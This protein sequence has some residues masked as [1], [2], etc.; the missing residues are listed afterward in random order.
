MKV[1]KRQGMSSGSLF[2]HV[3]TDCK[4]DEED[5]GKYTFTIN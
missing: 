2:D 3:E 5:D 4:M 1:M